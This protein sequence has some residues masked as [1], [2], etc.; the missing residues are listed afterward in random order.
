MLMWK[1]L[2][3]ERCVHIAVERNIFGTFFMYN[4]SYT[5]SYDFCR[6]RVSCERIE[7]RV[8]MT[9]LPFADSMR[10]PR[11]VGNGRIEFMEKAVPSVG[12][13]QLLI[14]VKANALCGT[15]RRQFY[16]GSEVTPG[17]EAA[18]IVVATG[19][20]TQTAVGTLGVIFLMDFCSTCRSCRRGFTN[21]C[22]HKRGD[23]GFNKDGGYGAYELVHETNFFPLDGDIAL[24]DATLLLDIMGTGGHVIKRSRLVHPDIE[25]VVV[26][27]AGPIGLA[28]LV[29]AKLLLGPQIPV[30]ISDVSMYRL[31]LAESLGGKPIQLQKMTLQEGARKH[32]LTNIDLAV[33]SS[34]KRSARQEGLGL[35]TKRGVLVCVGHGEDLQLH[36][37]SDLIAPERAVLGSEYFAY[38]EFAENIAF[39]RQHAAYLRQIITHTYS[40]SDIQHAFELFFGGKTGKVVIVQ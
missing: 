34:G 16:E 26:T 10:V 4:M 23:M 3:W 22:L 29:M 12:P 5:G 40:V 27:G 1:K 13:G 33:D 8:P 24:T 20:E 19:S 31:E 9:Q 21:Q 25:S 7:K 37:S 28:V 17:H 38:S 11:F 30:L 39:L 32:G 2:N 18:G 36:V 14:A 15:E 6:K 35:L